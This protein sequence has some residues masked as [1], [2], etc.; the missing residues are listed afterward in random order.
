M[1][2]SMRGNREPSAEDWRTRTRK[3]GVGAEGGVAAVIDASPVQQT[4]R[5]RIAHLFG[6][7][8]RLAPVGRTTVQRVIPAG[9]SPTK[10]HEGQAGARAGAGDLRSAIQLMPAAVNFPGTDQLFMFRVVVGEI[11][12]SG[13]VRFE[14][15]S[16]HNILFTVPFGPYGCQ[17]HIHFSPA[18]VA[19]DPDRVVMPGDTARA[20]L[21]DNDRNLD[22]RYICNEQAIPLIIRCVPQDVMGQAKQ[23]RDIARYGKLTHRSLT[24]LSFALR[25]DY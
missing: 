15:D 25:G 18:D 16:H 11:A 5:R 17:V 13:A 19:Y 1:E 22:T 12:P 21:W 6:E 3:G 23:Q 20:H 24:G 4:Q 10:D 14:I 2:R 7:T 9:A 8:A